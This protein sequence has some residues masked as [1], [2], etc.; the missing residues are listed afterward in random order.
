MCI[1]ISTNVYI[2]RFKLINPSHILTLTSPVSFRCIYNKI[3]LFTDT[4]NSEWRPT[5][6]EFW[7]SCIYSTTSTIIKKLVF[8]HSFYH[9]INLRIRSVLRILLL[10]PHF[11]VYV[12][13]SSVVSVFLREL[14][15]TAW[16]TG[17]TVVNFI[18]QECRVDYLLDFMIDFTNLFTV[19]VLCCGIENIDIMSHTQAGKVSC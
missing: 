15:I 7:I 1:K 5:L 14:K 2:F 11:Y 8:I 10:F 3:W 19:A 6:A 17:R 12:H 18:L 4:K 16:E 13:L 9:L